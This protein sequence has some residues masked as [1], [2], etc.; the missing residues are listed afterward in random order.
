MD[1]RK[2]ISKFVT[3]ICEKNYSQASDSLDSVITE[4]VKNRI[5]NVKN[6]IED[7]K[8]KKTKISKKGLKKVSKKG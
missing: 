4:K 2:L 1:L 5:K 7:K 6:K 3:Q 8:E